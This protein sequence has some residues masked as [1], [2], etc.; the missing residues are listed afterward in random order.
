ML[1]LIQQKGAIKVK[2]VCTELN[3]SDFKARKLLN[4]MLANEIISE[5][6]KSVAHRYRFNL[7]DEY[8]RFAVQ[9]IF[10]QQEEFM[11]KGF[12]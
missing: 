6:G 11:L 1:K 3:L 5:H 8:S 9:Q 2:D 10:H 12:D 4:E 7:N